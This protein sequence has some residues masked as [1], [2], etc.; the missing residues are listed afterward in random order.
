[1]I[2]WPIT[3]DE[4]DIYIPNALAYEPQDGDPRPVLTVRNNVG[5]DVVSGEIEFD[6]VTPLYFFQHRDAWDR[7]DMT[8]GEYTYR[9]TLGEG[10]KVLSE[11][12]LI[13][14]EYQ[15]AANIQYDKPTTYEQYEPE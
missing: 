12:L 15:P 10:G 2:Y 8:P 6:S 4:F 13:V 1:M 14:G 3:A 11:G 5:L 9:L 7:S